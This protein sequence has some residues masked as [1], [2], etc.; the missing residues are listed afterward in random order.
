MEEGYQ[1]DLLTRKTN[2]TPAIQTRLEAIVGMMQEGKWVDALLSWG[3]LSSHHSDLR[4]TCLVLARELR[5]LGRRQEAESVFVLMMHRYP[6]DINPVLDYSMV[7]YAAREWP[8]AIRRFQLMRS[9]FP[10]VLDGYRFV[11]DLLVGQRR[12]DEADAVL[13]EGMSRFPR[14]VCLAK[15]YGWSAHFSGDQG[16]NWE[17]ARERWYA[18]VSKFPNEQLGYAMLGLVLGKYLGRAAEAEKLLTEAMARFPDDQAIACQYARA[19]DYRGDWVEALRRWD[20]LLMRWPKHPAALEGRGETEVRRRL[21]E[22]DSLQ[23]PRTQDPLES[24]TAG[25]AGSKDREE[26]G[27]IVMRFESLGEDCE[28]G[29]VQ[30]HFGFEPLGLLRWVSVAPE[31]LCL[32]LEEGFASLD[33][34]TDLEIKLI[35]PEYHTHGKR[36]AMRMHTHILQSEYKGSFQQLH[37]QLFRRLRY[38]KNKLLDDLKSAE[39]VLVWQSGIGSTLSEA[40]V[41]RMHRAVRNYGSNTL[42]VVRRDGDPTKV[43]NIELQMPGLLTG[44]LRQ[45]DKVK[46]SDGKVRV[47]SPFSGWLTLCRQALVLMD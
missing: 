18:L 20:M 12:F 40:V 30:R 13:R 16:G 41:L 17:D 4:K 36:Y 26:N 39:K 44:T 22:I 5:D 27:D 3:D 10:D 29:L 47:C 32:A 46:G 28:F 42:L 15:S 19:A 31:A 37:A 9:R 43:P 24:L 8:E 25:G 34:V 45:V 2:R 7:A 33:D 35:G 23:V 21:L 1:R 6:D 14:E 38:L 11:S